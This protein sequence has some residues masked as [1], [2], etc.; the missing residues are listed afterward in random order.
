MEKSMCGKPICRVNQEKFL[1][2]G[3]LWT[4]FVNR[5]SQRFNLMWSNLSC[6]NWRLIHRSKIRSTSH[7]SPI[8]W[9]NHLLFLNVCQRQDVVKTTPNSLENTL[10]RHIHYYLRMRKNLSAPEYLR[11]K[12]HI[13]PQRTVQQSMEGS[14]LTESH[15][16]P[17][18][19]CP[20]HREVW[21]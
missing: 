11:G 18:D 5:S 6:M 9:L 15:L 1:S 17:N 13:R 21:N 4:R 20:K 14:P 8:N 10:S 19:V 3:L 12:H 2:L 7:C 16:R